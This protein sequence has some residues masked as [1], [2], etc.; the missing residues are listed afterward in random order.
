MKSGGKAYVVAIAAISS[1]A[2][3]DSHLKF[4]RGEG[5]FRW[6]SLSEFEAVHDYTSDVV[7]ISGPWLG[8]DAEA[9]E[10]VLT[11]FEAVT[12]ATV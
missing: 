5:A 9:A 8:S 1:P 3:A 11:Y 6:E 12:G 10:A 7:T 2:Y 4:A